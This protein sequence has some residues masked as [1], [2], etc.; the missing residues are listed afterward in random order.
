MMTCKETM[1]KILSDGQTPEVLAHLA[2]CPDC[3]ALAG[4]WNILKAHSG[5][6]NGAEP[7]VALDLLIC[8][9]AAEHA[10]AI[11]AQKTQH[12]RFSYW[13]SAVAAL[14]VIC[15]SGLFFGLWNHG[16]DANGITPVSV[17]KIWENSEPD[18]TGLMML[19]LDMEIASEALDLSMEDDDY[20]YDL[21]WDY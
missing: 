4:E 14:F 3:A 18:A 21:A 1:E 12:K 9:A 10:A 8:S 6:E 11:R 13:I 15:F 16:V 17:Y 20:F 7:P 19:S 2:S 5:N